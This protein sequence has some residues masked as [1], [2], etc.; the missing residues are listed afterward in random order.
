M[1][2][3]IL[4]S[5]SQKHRSKGQQTQPELLIPYLESEV[6]PSNSAILQTNKT[7]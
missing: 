6:W 3:S 1:K 2:E 4:N 5:H 7:E